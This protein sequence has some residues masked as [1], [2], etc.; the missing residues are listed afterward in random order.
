MPVEKRSHVAYCKRTIQGKLDSSKCMVTGH[1]KIPCGNES[2]GREA[3]RKRDGM[4]TKRS[5]KGSFGITAGKARWTLGCTKRR[6]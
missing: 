6:G 3:M 5:L 2:H 1:G 4:K